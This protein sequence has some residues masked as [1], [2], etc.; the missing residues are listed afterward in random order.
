[1][2]RKALGAMNYTPERFG[3][4]RVGDFF[5]ALAGH[6]EAELERFKC[7]AEL[8]RTSTTI[9]RNAHVINESDLKTAEQLWHFPW[10]KKEEEQEDS[11]MLTE[12]REETETD[13]LRILKR[14]TENG[15]SNKPAEGEIRS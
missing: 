3:L 7:S 2:Y 6:D 5:D 1:M 8:I 12:K 15:H 10:D 4:M 11:E 14:Q 9:L 13:L